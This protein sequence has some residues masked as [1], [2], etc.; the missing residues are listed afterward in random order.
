MFNQPWT[1]DRL[2]A[3]ISAFRILPTVP[4]H[5]FTLSIPH[6]TFHIP[7]FRILP[8]AVLFMW[9]SETVRVPKCQ[10]LFIVDK[11]K[12]MHMGYKSIQAE[13]VM[14]DVKLECV[15]LAGPP[16]RYY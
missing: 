5:F 7:Q 12:A 13:Y 3:Q 15:L 8:I 9:G 4:H 10:M 2:H 14:N 16:Q 1:N 6:F 11:C